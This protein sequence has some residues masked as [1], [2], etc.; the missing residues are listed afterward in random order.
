[1]TDNA[2]IDSI[3]DLSANTPL[4][5][6]DRLA[7]SPGPSIFAKLE[8]FLPGGSS[9]DRAVLHHI[10]LGEREGRIRAESVLV[11]PTDG[12]SGIGAA[13]IAALKGYG[14]IVVIPE[15]QPEF[16][17]RAAKVYGAE[18]VTT[19][20]KE[21]MQGAVDRANQLINE[22]AG[23]RVMINLY[24]GVANAEAHKKSTAQEI[25]KVLGKDVDA[26][27]AGVGSGGTLTGCAEIMKG[28]NSN[29]KVFAVE[30]A[31]SNVLGGGK[32]QP[33]G[34]HGLG[35][36]FVPRTLN[37]SLIDQIVSV[38]LAEASEAAL[39][40]AKKEGLLVGPEGGAVIAAALRIAPQFTS[41]QDIVVILNGSG[42]NYL[43]GE[44]FFPPA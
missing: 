15:G 40:L 9:T 29:L 11:I 2:L 18:V 30:P 21:R 25:V 22:N 28:L 32:P 26:L 19:P 23:I 24:D 31:E 34:M 1:M 12:P 42:R 4:L 33:H 27:V 3:L 37:Q 7:P 10:E 20:E 44:F 43:D 13:L 35:V 38:S 8:N 16:F 36:G 41:D 6:L 17:S 14:C 39:N 5:R